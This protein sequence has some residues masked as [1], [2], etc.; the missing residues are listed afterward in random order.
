MIDNAPARL[1]S[2]PTRFDLREH[3]SMRGNDADEAATLV[4]SA[5]QLPI[6]AIHG[7]GT[8]EEQS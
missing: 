5:T 6:I 8:P 3:Y 2:H 7:A 1:G 4:N